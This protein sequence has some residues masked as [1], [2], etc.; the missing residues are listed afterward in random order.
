MLIKDMAAGV[1]PA[2][3]SLSRI[4]GWARQ[5]LFARLELL[6]EGR[7]SVIEPGST[8]VF[9][10][11]GGIHATL[12]VTDPAFFRQ[13]VLGGSLGASESY[14]A[15]QWTSPDLTA[16]CRVALLNADVMDG[17]ETGWARLGAQLARG[18][19]WIR[20]NTVDGSRENIHA[21]Y[22]LGN[23]FFRLFLDDTMTYSCGIFETPEASLRDA[24][25]AKIDRL[26]RKLDLQPGDRLLEIGTGWGAFA[27]HA[28]RTY[29]CQ[30]TTTTISREQH[31]IAGERIRVAG[32]AG[33]VELLLEDYR[34]LRGRYDKLVSVEMI[35]AVG[36]EFLPS[37]FER[38]SS[39]L[40][41]HGLMALQGIVLTDHRYD[42]YCRRVEFI[43]RYVFPG[44]HLPAVSE[45]MNCVR[46]RSD[47]AVEHLEDLSTHYAATLRTW[48]R[49]FWERIEDVRRL[50]YPE[51]FVR[52]WDYYLSYCEAGFLERNCRVVQMLLAKPR[53]R[54]ANL[55]GAIA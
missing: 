47:L 40:E 38:C 48:R 17:M 16:L 22:D 18:F 37:Y 52:L 2:E 11:E 39:L 31:G 43:Q 29:G 13:A 26:C 8:R 5:L 46:R 33:R 10:G 36:R 6:R 7:I 9:G 15:G 32:L 42:A 3:G 21:H 25:I 35:E 19:H 27:I 41:P 28:A 4:D 49:R 53:A 55:T 20:R 34:G 30:V 51:P 54:R 23:D 24:S 50:G 12:S 1:R 14:M 44:S 45:M